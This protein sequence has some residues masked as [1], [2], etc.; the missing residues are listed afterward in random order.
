MPITFNCPTCD[1]RIK[2]PNLPGKLVNCA[3]CGRSVVIP[4]LE[5]SESVD[6]AEVDEPRKTKESSRERHCPFCDEVI[7]P[8]AKKCRYCGEILDPPEAVAIRRSRRRE[9]EVGFHCPFC[10]ANDPPEVRS[11]ISTAGWVIFVV[12]LIGCF[13]LCII[14]LFIK[15][16]YRVC[17]SCGIKLG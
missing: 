3:G 9:P 4:G 1:H 8:D 14:G 12:L 5:E 17:S 2:A 10:Q 15:E 11:K 16:D 6:V 7:R 13:P